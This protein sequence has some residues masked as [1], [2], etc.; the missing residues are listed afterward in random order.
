MQLAHVAWPAVGLQLPDR[1]TRRCFEVATAA[2]TQV[3]EEGRNEEWNV[4][5]DPSEAAQPDDTV[6][7]LSTLRTAGVMSD[8]CR[9]GA[10]V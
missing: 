2:P 3:L 8:M 10:A 4:L 7:N 9:S 1:L 6:S 5:R